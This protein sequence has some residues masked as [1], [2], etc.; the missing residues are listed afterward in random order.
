[1][2]DASPAISVDN[3]AN[4]STMPVADNAPRADSGRR[5]RLFALLATIV[6][7]LAVVYGVWYFITQAG[8]VHTDDAYV[9]ADSAQITPLV[10]GA[11]SDV[12]VANTQFVHRGDVLVIIDGADARVDLSSAEAALQL[13]RQHF[14][15]ASAGVSSAAGRVSARN[16]DIA[17]ARARLAEANAAMERATRELSRRQ[18]LDV[19]GAVSGEEITTAR[20]ALASARAARDFAAA[21]VQ[22]A[23]AS[24][25]SAGGDLA[26]SSALVAGT[27]ISSAPEVQAAQARVDAAR[28]GVSRTVIRAPIDGV[29]TNKQVQIGQRIA[30][31]TPIMVI[32]PT[33]RAFVDAN[34]KEGQF[35]R[36]RIGQPAEVTSDFYGGGVVFH[37]H[38]VGF[39]GGTGAAFSLIPAQ[40]A[41]GNWIKVVQRLPVRIALDAAEMRRHPLRIGLSMDVTVDTR[42]H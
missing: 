24:V 42:G 10:S 27:S 6:L 41:S 26:A 36:L 17:Q 15:Q 28:L 11:V 40:N 37:G 21:G 23:S 1:M 14:R 4:Q 7:V 32:V 25:A 29:V 12:R 38:V 30:A 9:G 31:G 39:A 3:P 5:K 20:S 34:F 13:A 35:G 22:A 33:D 19:S 2:A 18:G 16:A 8:R